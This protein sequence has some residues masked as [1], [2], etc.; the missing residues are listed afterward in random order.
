MDKLIQEILYPGLTRRTAYV[1]EETLQEVFDSIDDTFKSDDYLVLA[2]QFFEENNIPMSIKTLEIAIES[3]NYDNQI[4][5]NLGNLYYKNA[6]PEKAFSTWSKLTSEESTIGLNRVVAEYNFNSS[7]IVEAIKAME[8]VVNSG[9]GNEEDYFNLGALYL[10]IDDRKNALTIWKQAFEKGKH[11]STILYGLANLTDDPDYGIK[12]FKYAVEDNR[13]YKAFIFLSD[14]LE[15]GNSH[16]FIP[17]ENLQRMMVKKMI[18]NGDFYQM[19]E[20]S[21]EAAHIIKIINDD[22]I[23]KE[24]I[25]KE[26]EKSFYDEITINEILGQIVGEDHLPRPVSTIEYDGKHFYIMQQVSGKTYS[27]IDILP[28]E[29]VIET[30]EHLAAIHVLMPIKDL[31]EYSLLDVVS[32][33]F[34]VND[35]TF[36]PLIKILNSSKNIGYNNS[37]TVDNWMRSDEGKLVILDTENKGTVPYSVDLAQF[38]VSFD[39][40]SHEQKL[41][42]AGIYANTVN[43]FADDK[44]LSGKKINDIEMFREEFT[45]AMVFRS[46]TLS[47]YFDDKGREEDSRKVKESGNQALDYMEKN[48]MIPKDHVYEFTRYRELLS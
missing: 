41:N 10:Q 27:E 37:S 31:K 8:K 33:R 30:L 36:S 7:D 5:A 40:I 35:K 43:E 14:L 45:I 34:G 25:I 4:L 32:K 11:N 46:L 1:H 17:S 38:L 9:H 2:G 44:G 3:E 22:I 39:Y 29:E 47:K 28:P 18:D 24:L 16:L 13:D 21:R 15:R 6:Q 42:L 12:L 48:G 20:T 23:S 19:L 26:G